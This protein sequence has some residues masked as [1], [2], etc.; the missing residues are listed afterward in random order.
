[1]S[2]RKEKYLRH[3]LNEA[4][5]LEGVAVELAAMGSRLESRDA[6][7]RA[8]AVCVSEFSRQRDEIRQVPEPF[9]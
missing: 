9:T 8:C 1:M 3:A 2:Q 4:N 6:Y 7:E 5:R